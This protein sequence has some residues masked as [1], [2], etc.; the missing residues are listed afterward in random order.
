[1]S[2]NSSDSSVAL[3]NTSKTKATKQESPCSNWC[4]TLNNWTEEEYS[5]LVSYLSSNSSYI[6]GKEI[7]EEGTPHLQGWFCLHKKKRFT[8]IKKIFTRWHVEKMKGTRYDNLIYCSKQGDYVANVYVPK[9]LKVLAT[10][11]LYEWQREIIEIIRGPPDDRSIFWFWETV[12]NVGKSTFTKYLCHHFHGIPVEGKKNDILYCAACY[13][14][15]L[16]IFDFERTMEDFISYGAI[17]KI[18]NG[19]FMCSKYESKP[20]I[21]NSP[22]VIIF[23]NF[24]PNYDA[25]SADR[26]VVKKL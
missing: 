16:Y 24:E 6:I 25:L 19:C 26:W 3:G 11:D 20:I 21:R 7:G 18:K 15:D 23:A 13:E 5:Y 8:G 9:P 10:K 12:G 2:V 22:H 1:M 14:S 4:F 17:E